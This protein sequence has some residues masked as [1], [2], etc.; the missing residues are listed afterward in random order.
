MRSSRYVHL[1][2]SD[3]LGLIL[4]S[5]G[6]PHGRLAASFKL[7]KLASEFDPL[8]RV[9]TLRE[10]RM[11]MVCEWLRWLV[12]VASVEAV[13]A[14]SDYMSARL[15]GTA[16]VGVD[17]VSAEIAADAIAQLHGDRS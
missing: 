9:A 2:K 11:R 6:Q 12:P 10:F 8:G 13:S 4:S 7:I 16:T 15:N 1:G 14:V 3:E 5:Y 17:H